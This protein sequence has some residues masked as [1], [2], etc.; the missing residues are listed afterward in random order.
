M[1]SMG[2]NLSL[3]GVYKQTD[4]GVFAHKRDTLFSRRDLRRKWE[5]PNRT[6]RQ[7]NDAEKRKESKNL[8]GEHSRNGPNGGLYT[9][10]V[11]VHPDSREVRVEGR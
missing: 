10:I 6:K 9:L 8:S 7:L 5:R 2:T 3:T 11:H 1:P 4:P